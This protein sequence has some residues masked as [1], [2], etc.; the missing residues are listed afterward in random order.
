MRGPWAWGTALLVV[1]A[2]AVVPAAEA[3]PAHG[4]KCTVKGTPGPDRLHGSALRDVICGRGGNDR[5]RSRGGD[6]LV[7]SGK[8]A[9]VVD[10]G[11]GADRVLGGGGSDMIDGA[12]DDDKLDG[13]LGADQVIG[14]GGSDTCVFSPEDRFDTDCLYD[15]SIRDVSISPASI[16]TSEQ[17]ADVTV[18]V[19]IVHSG[20]RTGETQLTGIRMAEESDASLFGS[21]FMGFPTSAPPGVP[22][23]LVAGD[24]ESGTWTGT[25]TVPQ[26]S[27][28]GEHR[29]SLLL[30]ESVPH[31][32]P[33]YRVRFDPIPYP[34]LKRAWLNYAFTQVGA[35]DSGGPVVESLEI[36]PRTVD[37]SAGEAEVTLE[38]HVTDDL[39][40]AAEAFG[41]LHPPWDINSLGFS[42]ERTSGTARDGVWTGT[43]ILPRWSQ[44]GDHLVSFATSDG[45]YP[46]KNSPQDLISRGVDP[47]L[48][49]VGEGDGDPPQLKSLTFT[50][51]PG[52]VTVDAGVAD[53]KSGPFF[54]N[55]GADGPNGAF[56][57]P[58]FGYL[59]EP[60]KSGTQADGVW[61]RHFSLDPGTYS[62]VFAETTD[63]QRNRGLYRR[64]D[65][66]AAGL[67]T[68]FTV[69]A[70]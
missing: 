36:T 23:T 30:I 25:L 14:G 1:L 39:R 7:R 41:T 12:D 18:T 59:L 45:L 27:A 22:L 34:G 65:L 26:Y 15:Y 46:G 56:W 67:Q 57:Q 48:H 28:P 61:E 33:E 70:G 64:A 4:P 19:Q 54:F 51:T 66:E 62:L 9:D 13:E 68:E 44:Q 47:A 58:D 17:S 21:P 5:I 50:P 53:P 16:D 8:G 37:T 20:T 63:M 42:L 3:R 29:I 49:Q 60:P 32:I 40:G 38:A 55:L 52:G 31:P 2:V 69:P 6:D 10:G 24:S 11:P 43:L 35:G